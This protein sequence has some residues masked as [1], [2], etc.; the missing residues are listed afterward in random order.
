MLNVGWVPL[1]KKDDISTDPP[2]EEHEDTDEDKNFNHV[3]MRKILYE[4]YEDD[5][6]MYEITGVIRSGEE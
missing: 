4:K 6:P 3:K 5:T 1:D 2:V